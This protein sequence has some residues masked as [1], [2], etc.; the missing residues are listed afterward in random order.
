MIYTRFQGI[1]NYFFSK[2]NLQT[3]DK[4]ECVACHHQEHADL[5]GAKNIVERGHRL[6]ACGENWVA[7]LGEPGSLAINWACY[8]ISGRNPLSLGRGGPQNYQNS[9]FRGR[10]YAS[11]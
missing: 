5:V 2:D 4:F 6:L 9:G 1:R 3:Q 10:I 11:T 8:C 7:K